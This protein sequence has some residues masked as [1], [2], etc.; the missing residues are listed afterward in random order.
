MYAN[1]VRN[2][3]RTAIIRS[4]KIKGGLAD[5]VRQKVRK[6]TSKPLN[7]IFIFNRFTNQIEN[8]VL[9]AVK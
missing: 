4:A 3:A 9:E 8:C 6:K 5:S 7:Q 2:K 1:W